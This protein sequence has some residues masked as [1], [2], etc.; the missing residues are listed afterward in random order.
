M[1]TG[2]LILLSIYVR[3]HVFQSKLLYL[4]LSCNYFSW[5]LRCFPVVPDYNF[6][7]CNNF[8]QACLLEQLQLQ[9]LFRWIPGTNS[10]ALINFQKESFQQNEM[11]CK[12]YCMNKIGMAKMQ[13]KQF[14]KNFSRYGLNRTCVQ[15][16]S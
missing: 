13:S 12:D 14:Q 4:D 8:Q 6:I 9:G 10:K 11:F 1:H 3:I 15:P 7:N 16:I 2:M 5:C